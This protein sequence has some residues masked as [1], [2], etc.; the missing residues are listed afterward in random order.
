MGAGR[1]FS[2]G[3]PRPEGSRPSVVRAGAS[4][5]ET[6]C[7]CRRARG[8]LGE[9][10][11]RTPQEA[12]GGVEGRGSGR[13]GPLPRGLDPR[14]EAACFPRTGGG[15]G[16]RE[17]GARGGRGAARAPPPLPGSSEGEWAPARGSGGGGGGGAQTIG[18][19]AFKA[20]S[21]GAGGE[22]TSG[23]GVEGGCA[24]Q[25]GGGAGR[26]DCGRLERRP[27][28]AGTE[29]DR[30]RAGRRA[31]ARGGGG[32]GARG[33]RGAGPAGEPARRSGGGSGGAGRSGLG[34]REDSRAAPESF[35]V[36]A[37]TEA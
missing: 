1:G 14:T 27:G 23:S 37:G 35:F 7:V 15:S 8:P 36:V 16:G 21:P 32:A 3:G 29:H 22:G 25:Q 31:G 2:P 9:G 30:G 6:E 13:D 20:G 11:R 17:E 18:A 33:R 12:V 28:R 19:C 24:G 10:G 5:R 26:A 34:G 4:R